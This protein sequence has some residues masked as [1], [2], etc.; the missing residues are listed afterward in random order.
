MPNDLKLFCD[1]Y[2]FPE[3]TIDYQLRRTS[4]L[5]LPKFRS[6]AHS[7]KCIMYACA[8]WLKLLNMHQRRVLVI[9][10]ADVSVCFMFSIPGAM[11]LPGV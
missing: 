4:Q 5:H 1:K 10:R 3:Y 8:R 9:N 6:A 11:K 2:F 7:K